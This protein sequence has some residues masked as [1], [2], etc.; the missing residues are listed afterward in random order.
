M[1]YNFGGPGFDLKV[2]GESVKDIM[3][4]VGL[5]Q[6]EH[7]QMMSHLIL[8]WQYCL[9]YATEMYAGMEPEA[10]AQDYLRTIAQSGDGYLD[11]ARKIA[12]KVSGSGL[13]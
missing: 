5:T 11:A 13:W 9:N 10:R 6:D 4:S 12:D 2:D 3:N 1:F 7:Y 8:A